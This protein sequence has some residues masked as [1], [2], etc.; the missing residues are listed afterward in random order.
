MPEHTKRSGPDTRNMN[1]T[2]F[3]EYV[4]ISAVLNISTTGNARV[5]GRFV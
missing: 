1:S 2:I 3:V 5:T 4:H